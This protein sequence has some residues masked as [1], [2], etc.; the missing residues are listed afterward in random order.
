MQQELPPV[1]TVKQ[2]KSVSKYS[3]ASVRPQAITRPLA[4]ENNASQRLKPVKPDHSLG[5]R[6][7]N[8]KAVTKVEALRFKLELQTRNLGLIKEHDEIVRDLER[9]GAR[10]NKI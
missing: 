1:R 8:I 4:L 7:R 9:A 5:I 6:T 2:T 10:E 3:Y